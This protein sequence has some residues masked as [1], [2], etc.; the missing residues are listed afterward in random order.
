M[1]HAMTRESFIQR[2]LLH[3]LC[4]RTSDLFYD[5]ESS[6]WDGTPADGAHNYQ[7]GSGDFYTLEWNDSELVGL[8]FAHESERSQ[9]D[10]DEDERQP[11]KH[12]VGLPEACRPLVERSLEGYMCEELVT[13]GLWT[14]GDRV[15]VTEPWHKPWCHG[16]E[17]LWRYSLPAREAMLGS[18]GQSWL[19]LAS[20]TAAQAEVLLSLA[21]RLGQGPTLISIQEQAILLEPPPEQ[22]VR[23]DVG[24]YWSDLSA[25][26]IRRT[27]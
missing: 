25:V 8:V 2:A 13:A 19:E 11:Y 9:W 21:R 16:L 18:E 7:D 14:E 23:G 4:Q 10:L 6:V 15:V 3:H 1:T 22:K 17:M 27:S 20:L 24:S 12:L 5:M 26:G